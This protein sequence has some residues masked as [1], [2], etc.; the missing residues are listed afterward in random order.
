MPHLQNTVTISYSVTGARALTLELEPAF[1]F[2]KHGVSI[3]AKSA[4]SYTAPNGGTW[5]NPTSI[6]APRFARFNV[7]VNY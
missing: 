7:T 1:D 3:E 5:L 6:L 4:Y 2:R